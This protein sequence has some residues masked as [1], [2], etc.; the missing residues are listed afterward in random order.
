MA[1]FLSKLT[2]PMWNWASRRYQAAVAKELKKY[3]L[4]YDDLYDEMYD[5]DIQEAL[6]RLPRSVV[7]ARSARIK[8]AMDA[9]M[10]HVYLDKEL[11]AKQTPYD[12][13]L[14]DALNL[15]KLERKERIELGSSLP[16]NREIP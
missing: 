11:Q 14:Q 13:Y 7:D 15:V 16:Y 2:E 4:R 5:V 12:Y 10:K 9:S 8:R 6:S 1:K 3:G